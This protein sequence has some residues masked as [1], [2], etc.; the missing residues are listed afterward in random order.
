VAVTVAVELLAMA[1]VVTVKVVDVAAAATV[2]EAGTVRVAL[3]FVRVTLA[4]PVGAAW[5][6]VTVHVLEELAPMPVG[7][8][9][10]DETSTGATRLTVVLAELLL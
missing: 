9:V 5:V 6:R 1:P 7:L 3:E 4:P 10:N 2:T 8:Q